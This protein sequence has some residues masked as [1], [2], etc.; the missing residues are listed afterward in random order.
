[1]LKYRGVAGEINQPRR[2]FYTHS[3][4]VRVRVRVVVRADFIQL[5]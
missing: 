1:M 5:V 2:L 3:N 4:T